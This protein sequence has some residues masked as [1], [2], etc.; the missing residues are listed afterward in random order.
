MPFASFAAV[1]EELREHPV[2]A[3][4]KVRVYFAAS[5]I[6][7]VK[8]AAYAATLYYLFTGDSP[9]DLMFPHHTIPAQP[10]EPPEALL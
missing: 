9:F 7:A 1:A 6:E 8:I 10:I 5:F 3:G 4:E 2:S